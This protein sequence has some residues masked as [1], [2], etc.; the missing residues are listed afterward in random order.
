MSTGDE[1]SPGNYGLKDQALALKW[2]HENIH[3]FGGDPQQVTLMGQSKV[4]NSILSFIDIVS[5]EIIY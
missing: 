5:T 1:A 4:Q 3:H 2:I